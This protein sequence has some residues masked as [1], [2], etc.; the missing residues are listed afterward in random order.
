MNKQ[1]RFANFLRFMALAVWGMAL[2]TFLIG[3]LDAGVAQAAQESLLL[4]L[5][6]YLI[7]RG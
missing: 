6:L 7:V 3:L 2:G 1:R 5:L 4:L